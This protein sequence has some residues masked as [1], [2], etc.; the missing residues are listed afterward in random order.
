MIFSSLSRLAIME[1][2]IEWFPL[3]HFPPSLN[4][5]TGGLSSGTVPWS[6]TSVTTVTSSPIGTWGRHPSGS[7][8][9]YQH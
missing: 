7:L 4:R 2:S 5:G 9:G 3:I 8:Q 1:S 6:N